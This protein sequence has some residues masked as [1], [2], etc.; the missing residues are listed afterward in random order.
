MFMEIVEARWSSGLVLGF[1]GR[2]DVDNSTL[3]QE[4]L[5]ALIKQGYIRLALDLSQLE[6][7]STAGLRVLL[8][9]LKS[10]KSF[11]GGIVLF[12]LRDYIKRILEIAGFTV[13]FPMYATE[14][15]ALA[16]FRWNH[17][18]ARFVK[19][20]RSGPNAGAYCGKPSTSTPSR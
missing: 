8:A 11:R 10:V 9:A 14:D 1:R 5:L 17:P 4:K 13:L 20:T 12:G 2:L 7:I 18:L 16:A 15:E 3:V 19:G 6:Y